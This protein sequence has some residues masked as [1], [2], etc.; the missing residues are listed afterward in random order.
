MP[1]EVLNCLYHGFVKAKR[2]VCAP[3]EKGIIGVCMVCVMQGTVIR[4]FG[5]PSGDKLFEFRRGM[6]RSVLA[7][8]PCIQI[9]LPPFLH[10]LAKRTKS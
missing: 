6:K 7:S 2:L 9:W 10:L 1:I 5:I 3:R 4:V 8:S